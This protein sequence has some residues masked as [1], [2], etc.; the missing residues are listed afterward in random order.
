MN[1]VYEKSVSKIEVDFLVR[2]KLPKIIQK[3]FRSQITQ[4][5]QIYYLL[6]K[7]SPNY[8]KIISSTNY[9]D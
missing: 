7:M 8:Q 6:S 1:S 4:I 5:K 9:T 3:L 2:Q